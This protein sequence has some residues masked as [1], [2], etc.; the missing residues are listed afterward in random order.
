MPPD[1]KLVEEEL[2]KRGVPIFL[3]TTEEIISKPLPLTKNDLVVGNFDWT[4]IATKQLGVELPTP[5]DY[6]DCLKHLLF[7]KVWK[8]TLSDI[9]SYL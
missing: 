9:H 5:P 4:R 1:Y 6:P 3:K 2:T 8:S 7:R